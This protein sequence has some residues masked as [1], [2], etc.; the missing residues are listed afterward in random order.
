MGTAVD[1]GIESDQLK[2]AGFITTAGSGAGS[3]PDSSSGSGL[4]SRA[5]EF[6]EGWNP[7]LY[8]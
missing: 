6:H 7:I 2:A 4:S 3:S 1:N 5:L 8:T